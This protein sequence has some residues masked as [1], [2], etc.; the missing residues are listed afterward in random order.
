MPQ[1]LDNIDPSVQYTLLKGDPG[2]TKSS[3]ALTYPKPQYWFPFDGKMQSLARAMKAH[4]IKGSDIHYDPYDTFGPALKK[5]EQFKLS[6]D[7]KTIVIDSITSGSDLAL[8]DIRKNKGTGGS[9]K[10]STRTVGGFEV[11][12]LEDYNG[13][14]SALSELIWLT[15]YLFE[16]KGINIVLIAH[17]IRKDEKS[18]DGKINIVRQI[19]TAAKAAAQ[20]IPAYCTEIYQFDAEPSLTGGVP[21]IIVKTVGTTE[22]YAR[23][24]LPL[25]PEIELNYDNLYEGYVLPAINLLKGV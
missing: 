9:D 17:V 7:Y 18:K 20:K 4:N 2:T 24:S 14:A 10:G 15:R 3:Q 8:R 11:N 21:K 25:E 19:V 12:I 23:T 5:L 16:N 22:D 1:S 6:C 13:E